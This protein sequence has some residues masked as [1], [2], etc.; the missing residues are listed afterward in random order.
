MALLVSASIYYSLQKNLLDYLGSNLLVCLVTLVVGMF[1]WLVYRQQRSDQVRDA[2][3]VVWT[4]IRQIEKEVSSLR[5][6]INDG[7]RMEVASL[8]NIDILPVDNW[9]KYQHIFS[10]ELDAV[11]YGELSAFYSAARTISKQVGQLK[12]VVPNQIRER[13]NQYID[14]LMATYTSADRDK[15]AKIPEGLSQYFH[16]D[17]GVYLPNFWKDNATAFVSLI[18]PISGMTVGDKLKRLADL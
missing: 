15:W 10:K 8:Q 9:V 7:A 11:D 3:L 5:A 4:E 18:H 16:V 6:W 2:A 1:A 17:G 12:E 14:S 13:Q